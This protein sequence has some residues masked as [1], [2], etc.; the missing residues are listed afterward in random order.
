M[1]LK[2]DLKS[3]KQMFGTWCII[4]CP[5]TVNILCK[6]GLDFVLIDFE[7]SPVDY[8]CAQKMI[9]AAHAENKKAVIRVSKLDEVEILRSLDIACDGIMVPHVETSDDVTKIISYCKYP[10]EG[11]RGYSPYTR[12]GGY[13]VKENYTQTANNN[14][15]V[16]AIIESV[17]GVN[18]LDKILKNQSLD[19]IY[20]GAYDL[21]VELGHPGDINH[22]DV[23]SVIQKCIDKS[24]EHSVSVGA[25]YHTREDYEYLK[26]NE[27]NFLVYK[28]D[29]LIINEGLLSVRKLKAY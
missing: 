9:M 6:S 12:A 1:T 29:S 19:M 26:K 17:K 27:V 2:N 4:P 13:C 28:V 23:Q 14:V 22:P 20:I 11:I 18:N 25:M 10:P 8:I 21:S 3:G 16:S 7:H 24:H 15:F 5:E